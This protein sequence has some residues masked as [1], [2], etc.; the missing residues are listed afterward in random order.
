MP[1]AN[2][3]PHLT[4]LGFG[5]VAKS[6]TRY[7][8]DNYSISAIVR[9]RREPQEAE[10][11]QVSFVQWHG[12]NREVANSIRQSTHIVSSVP[13]TKNG[14][15]AMELLASLL[16]NA[17]HLKWLAL[18]A[19]T[20]PYGDRGGAWV[21]ETAEIAPDHI[22][23]SLRTR[24]EIDWLDFHKNLSLPV[25]IFRLSGIYGPG[26]SAFD[27]LRNGRARRI[28]KP[29]QVFSRIHVDDIAQTL[30]ASMKR[31]NP[32]SIYNVA[33]DMPA[34]PQDVIEY[35]AKLLG[36]PVPPDEDF[37]TAEM[38][39]MARSFYADNRRVANAKIKSQL[40]VALEYVDYRAGLQAILALEN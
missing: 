23:A 33:D 27:K 14:D 38:S 37:A 6:L 19:T 30:A 40:G 39:P 11:P 12:T 18:L 34:P 35:A 16:E 20:G 31:P 24:Q 29:G 13:P 15:P 3:K 9:T 4:F 25:H 36:V 5:Y 26:R 7:L 32:G 22:R 2:L 21:D 17:K 10:F 8:R 28:I 1:E